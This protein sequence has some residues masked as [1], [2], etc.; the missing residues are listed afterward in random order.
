MFLSRTP[1]NLKE[2]VDKKSFVKLLFSNKK[3][4]YNN[5]EDLMSLNAP[6]AQIN[7]RH[8]NKASARLPSDD[9]G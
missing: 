1:A 6:V 9:M 4:A 2:K 5:H 7:A 8:S 3:V